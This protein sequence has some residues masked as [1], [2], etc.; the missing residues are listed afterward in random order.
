ML[1][2][3]VQVLSLT[4]TRLERAPIAVHVPCSRVCTSTDEKLEVAW[5]EATTVAVSPAVPVEAVLPRFSAVCVCAAAAGPP[6]ESTNEEAGAAG[7]R[8]GARGGRADR[9]R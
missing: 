4:L 8:R 6:E 7:R 9:R 5:P 2:L 3:A 1:P